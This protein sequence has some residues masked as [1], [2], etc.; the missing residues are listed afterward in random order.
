MQTPAA[1]IPSI[2]AA[3]KATRRRIRE[4]SR[5]YGVTE[6]MSH[7]FQHVTRLTG[8]LVL[9]AAWLA[10]AAV[11]DAQTHAH[12]H[13]R[14]HVRAA[15][16]PRVAAPSRHSKRA[17]ALASLAARSARQG[18]AL[19]ARPRLHRAVVHAHMAGDPAVSIVDFSFSPGTTTVHVGDTI[20]WMN[21]GKQPHSATANDHSFDTGLLRTGQSG[22]HTFNAPG[23]FTYFCIV[24]PYMHGTVV[25]LAATTT[26][27]TTPTSTTSTSTT[28]TSTTPTS[29]TPTSA[30]PTTATSG[31]TLPFTGTNDLAAFAIG[32]LLVGGGWGLRARSHASSDEREA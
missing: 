2:G 30:T 9:P 4:D 1:R 19:S 31:Q 16:P 3:K 20:T 7:R 29:T 8:I 27:S 14:R 18:L 26:T 24:H 5:P 23:T 22:S 25:V 11:A 6:D 10:L 21:T 32:L 12:H 28:P 17:T 13:A 15:K